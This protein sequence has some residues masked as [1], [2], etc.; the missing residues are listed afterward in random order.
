MTE[1]S[2]STSRWEQNS[3]SS[4]QLWIK[5]Q[6]TRQVKRFPPLKIIVSAV[7]AAASTLIV[8]VRARP[9]HLRSISPT[10][11]LPAFILCHSTSNSIY[12][13]YYAHCFFR[14][15][16]INICAVPFM[17]WAKKMCKRHVKLT[18]EFQ[19]CTAAQCGQKI[20]WSK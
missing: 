20:I 3:L 6:T 18:P 8:I 16:Y 4:H 17:S 12:A 10:C 15:L 13:W 19:M 1:L 2:L 7:V 14:R 11:L 5:F 9:S